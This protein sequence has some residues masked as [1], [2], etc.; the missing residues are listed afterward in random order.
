MRRVLILVLVAGLVFLGYEYSRRGTERPVEAAES[1]GGEGL[2][3]SG[4]EEKEPEI[5]PP[6]GREAGLEA[7]TGERLLEALD[8]GGELEVSAGDRASF[9]VGTAKRYALEVGLALGKDRDPALLERA[10]GALVEAAGVRDLGPLSGLLRKASERLL[11][12]GDLEAAIAALGGTNLVLEDR[13]GRR[14]AERL[15][16][17]AGGR[18]PATMVLR[19]SALLDALTHGLPFWDRHGDLI[20]GILDRE[21]EALEGLLFRTDGVWHSLHR[22]VPPGGTLDGIAQSV[23]RELR[24]PMSSGLLQM[25]N[26]IP[27]PR[28]VRA[29]RRIRIPVDP[30]H[31]VIEKDLF[32]MKVFLGKVLFRLYK[33]G[34]G[35][36]GRTP[37]GEFVV[38]EKQRHPDW[39]DP[40]TGRTWD[41]R[42]PKNPLGGYFIKLDHPDLKGYGIHGTIEPESI[43]RPSSMGCVRLGQEDMVEVFLFLPRR[44]KVRVV[45]SPRALLQRD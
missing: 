27:D 21:Q 11:D 31:A 10:A 38:I 14:L 17:A 23:E 36:E 26:G 19:L 34:L 2:P 29:G 30:L 9:P 33:V 37:R 3:R 40:S 32:A 28:R 4:V 45:T 12:S 5:L 7:K 22:R 24:I 35:K 39:M 15:A 20:A 25:V 1:E 41:G 44:A 42:D 16:E 18:N 43:G 8:K 13:E 6:A